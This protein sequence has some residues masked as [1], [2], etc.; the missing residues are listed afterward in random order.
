MSRPLNLSS[1]DVQAITSY[2]S[3]H[4]DSLSLSRSD[5]KQIADTNDALDF[6]DRKLSAEDRA[7]VLISM[8][9]ARL[10]QKSHGRLTSLSLQS[11]TKIEF[12]FAKKNSGNISITND[13]F[14]LLLIK[15]F[16]IP[17]ED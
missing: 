1:N 11:S 2:L 14:L 17:T 5:I 10:K 6:L 12:D 15:R 8:R 7:R 4:A 3:K 13:Q 9:Q 16:M